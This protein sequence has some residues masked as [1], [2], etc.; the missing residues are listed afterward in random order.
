VNPQDWYAFVYTTV[1]RYRGSV[2]HWGMW[3]EPNRKNFFSGSPAQYIDTILRVGAQAVREAD[4]NGYVLGPELA[5]EGDWWLWLNTVL[6][7]AAEAIDIVTQHSYQDIG[8][9]VL[10][11]LGGPV[12]PWNR[13]TV[14]DVMRW[15]GTDAKV[16]WLTETGWS[17]A[18]MSEEAQAASY[19][20]VLGGVEAYDWLNKVFFYGLVDDPASASKYGML[21]SDLTPKPAYEA[22]QRHIALHASTPPPGWS[23]LIPV[24]GWFGAETQGADMA[25]ADLNGNGQPDLVIFHID[26]PAGAN[27]GHYRIG[28]DLGANGLVRA[29]SDTIHLS[30]RFG[31]ETQGAGIALADVD[32]NDR[33]DLVVF[34]IDHSENNVGYYRIGWDLGSEEPEERWPASGVV[35]DGALAPME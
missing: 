15:T 6:D 13:P 26:A 8:D 19:K 34:H 17:T 23:D 10:Q 4:P 25:I 2:Q 20:Q 7:R 33:L 14:R 12:E 11:R 18:G 21:H 35:R 32:Q 27:A 16:L 5:Q 28:W 30:T 9:D 22:Y 3:N 24:P 29:W 1:S 31:D